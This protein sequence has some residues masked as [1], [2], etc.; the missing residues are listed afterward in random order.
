[1]HSSVTRLPAGITT[2]I[3]HV[4][5]SFLLS[6]L[7]ADSSSQCIVPS[8]TLFQSDLF[9]LVAHCK[10]SWPSIDPNDLF[11]SKV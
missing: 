5:N 1:M 3:S 4:K 6:P 9:Y 7:Q 8:S 10:F 2:S 11:S